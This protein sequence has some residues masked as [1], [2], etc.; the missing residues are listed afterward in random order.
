MNSA[1]DTVIALACKCVGAE[2]V[3]V[4]VAGLSSDAT[5]HKNSQVVLE[6][7]N[8][9]LSAMSL[10]SMKS[11]GPAQN[12]FLQMFSQYV[13][14]H[15][16][17][18]RD[19]GWL[20]ATVVA[21]SWQELYCTHGC[22]SFTEPFQ[23][24]VNRN[25]FGRSTQASLI[26]AL[27][28]VE[29]W[30][31]DLT[32]CTAHPLLRFKVSHTDWETL[33]FNALEPYYTVTCGNLPQQR[34]RNIVPRRILSKLVVRCCQA[35]LS[36]NG[37][38]LGRVRVLTE[39][40]C[41]ASRIITGIIVPWQLPIPAQLMNRRIRS[42]DLERNH[43]RG[44]SMLFDCD[45][46]YDDCGE[47]LLQAV[48]HHGIALIG[49]QRKVDEEMK[50]ILSQVGCVALE[51]LSIQHIRSVSLVTQA[52]ILSISFPSAWIHRL[53][54]ALGVPC[55]LSPI[56][57]AG[58]HSVHISPVTTDVNTPCPV[59]AIL[60]VAD[61]SVANLA[62]DAFCD[63]LAA[64]AGCI[65]DSRV[66][67]GQGGH[68]IVLSE[69]LAHRLTFT[70]PI[71]QSEALSTVVR[72]VRESLHFYAGLAGGRCVSGL[73]SSEIDDWISE[74][75]KSWRLHGDLFNL[76]AAAANVVRCG[77]MPE[78]LTSM[79]ALPTEHSSGIM[80]SRHIVFPSAFSAISRRVAITEENVLAQTNTPPGVSP[81]CWAYWD[82]KVQNWFPISYS[83][84]LKRLRDP[85]TA[86]GHSPSSD[87]E[88]DN[89]ENCLSTAIPPVIERL[90]PRLAA[91]KSALSMLTT[92]L[93]LDEV[94]WMTN[95]T[96]H[97][98]RQQGIAVLAASHHIDENPNDPRSII[99]S[100][101]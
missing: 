4:L 68:E 79:S 15:R 60:S 21:K 88:D 91:V 39:V 17:V 92:L 54:S 23:Q 74:Q 93:R 43:L 24:H 78:G 69:Y 61:L 87:D 35:V 99:F 34:Q 41:A 49:S 64:V 20:L 9:Q 71:V 72:T 5:Q 84:L 81:V 12:P 65:T 29:R 6:N 76:A 46:C 75:R 13:N 89:E 1:A 97:V 90:L 2:G 50:Y 63:A 96:H 70:P 27:R 26:A 56:A 77:P 40:S 11:N 8:N 7:I 52:E 16:R 25:K 47:E 67:V 19:G 55:Q 94:A 18:H 95:D 36:M 22:H 14:E 98:I 30:I 101:I 59:T 53:P 37:C 80:S 28:T 38:L 10:P 83:L 45:L 33:A 32:K 66:I 3:G 42:S 44:T 73:C 51:R 62:V 58:V 86:M 31:G 100:S 82:K 57:I 48:A 85:Q